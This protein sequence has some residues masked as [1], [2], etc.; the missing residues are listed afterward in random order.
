MS[1]DGILEPLDDLADKPVVR[2]P[3]L[4]VTARAQSEIRLAARWWAEN[5]PAAPQAFREDLA[6]AFSLVR[7][8]P[9]IGALARNARLGGVR[10]IYLARLR[11][12]LYYREREESVD[13]LAFWHASRSGPEEP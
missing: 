11:Y 9:R 7:A 10:R 2:R 12:H 4:R 8:Q 13:V 6:A 5:R 1:D 3:P